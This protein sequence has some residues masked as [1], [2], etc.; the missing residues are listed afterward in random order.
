[1]RFRR[2][3]KFNLNEP[4]TELKEYGLF[5]FRKPFLPPNSDV[6]CADELRSNVE[7]MFCKAGSAAIPFKADRI[8]YATQVSIVFYV[9]PRCAPCEYWLESSER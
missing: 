5:V 1:M 6:V 3:F 7:F 2:T 4:F 9:D 8:F